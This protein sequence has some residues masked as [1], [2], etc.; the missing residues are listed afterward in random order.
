MYAI[1][2]YMTN[3][4]ENAP[5]S[6]Y[7][8]GRVSIGTDA[9]TGLD[10]YGHLK[11]EDKLQNIDYNIHAMTKIYQDSVAKFNGNTAFAMLDS[12]V[13]MDLV[14]LVV[15]N[16]ASDSNLTFDDYCKNYGVKDITDDLEKLNNNSLEIYLSGLNG[17]VLEKYKNTI[18][19]L[20][21]SGYNSQTFKVADILKGLESNYLG[22]TSE[23]VVIRENNNQD[24]LSKV[25][26]NFDTGIQQH[27]D[28]EFKDLPTSRT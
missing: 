22:V 11:T 25:E 15:A 9:E 16:N 14:T 24:D 8:D 23:N 3:L 10:T 19:W 20:R 7:A 27:Q 21:N 5:F 12:V 4:N 26:Y 13:G 28:Y 2:N 1:S 18:A 17:T 6:V